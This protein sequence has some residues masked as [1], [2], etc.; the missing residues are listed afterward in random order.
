[1]DRTRLLN[2]ELKAAVGCAVVLEQASPPWRVDA[3]E[4]SRNAL[5]YRRGKGEIIIVNHAGRGW[6][7]PGHATAKGDV[8]DLVRYL[9]PCLSFHEA[10]RL[11]LQLAG[12][13]PAFPTLV[14]RHRWCRV[15]PPVGQRWTARR[16]LSSG[17][18]G[19][20]SPASGRCRKPFWRWQHRRMRSARA[21]R[22]APG[23][24]IAMPW[25]G[26]PVSRCEAH[27]TAG[28][29]PRERSRCSSS[30][31]EAVSPGWPCA[32]GRSMP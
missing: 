6:W 8:L 27:A 7:D 11:L 13:E 18:P 20:I 2:E 30:R 3:R 25:A 1:M 29:R 9:Q 14:T 26:S 28:S 31:A 22:A 23:S 17:S 19:A 12:I 15:L 10:R 24:R 32:R 5:K 16:A 4:S 21:R